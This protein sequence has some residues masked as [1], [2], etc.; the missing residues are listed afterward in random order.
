LTT[1]GVSEY[2]E[3]N[4]I[5]FM[6]GDNTEF[7]ENLLLFENEIKEHLTNYFGKEVEMSPIVK[8]SK[9]T[10]LPSFKIKIGKYYTIFDENRKQLYP[11]SKNK[12]INPFD[13]IENFSK[14]TVMIQFNG[15]FIPDESEV[16]FPS[17]TLCQIKLTK[18]IQCDCDL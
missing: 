16:V 9:T 5:S 12:E 8:Y 17:L 6:L 2:D 13:Y 15:F 11:S 18:P 4:Y 7:L 1:F 3:K 10:N 14:V